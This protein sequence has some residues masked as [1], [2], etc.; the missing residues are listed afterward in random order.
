MDVYVTRLD[1]R[2]V[3]DS[4]KAAA[5]FR[6]HGVTFDE[7]L[8]IFFDALYKLLDA[9]VAAEE[10]FAAIGLSHSAH[11]LYVVHS[12]QE[13]ETT[14]IIS[15]RLATAAERTTYEELA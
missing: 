14:R 12:E 1:E 11:L 5:N 7:A 2:F 9:S 3:W 10:R 13:G 8:E 4:E 6:K 15:A